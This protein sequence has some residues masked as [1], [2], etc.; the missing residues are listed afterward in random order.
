MITA[1][2]PPLQTRILNRAIQIFGAM[3]LSP[4]TPLAYLWSWGRALQ[5]L[6]GPD[7]VHYRAVARNEIKR[8]KRERGNNLTAEGYQ[9][10]R[11]VPAIGANSG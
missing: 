6:D 4:D 5:I 11:Y 3:G 2:V 7:E 1:L 9:H 8:A 10:G